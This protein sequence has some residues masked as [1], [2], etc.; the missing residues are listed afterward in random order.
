VGTYRL[1]FFCSHA[2]EGFKK[3]LTTDY[4]PVDLRLYCLNN[5]YPYLAV[6]NGGRPLRV[7]VEVTQDVRYPRYGG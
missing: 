6:P 7:V 4:H 3:A 2:A 5:D 1:C